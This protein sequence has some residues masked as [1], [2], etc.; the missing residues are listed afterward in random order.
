MTDE[1]N[2]VKRHA[3][4][5]PNKLGQGKEEEMNVKINNTIIF[6]CSYVKFLSKLNTSINNTIDAGSTSQKLK[7]K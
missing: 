4:P 3:V 5:S 2:G 7:S 6:Y 1:E